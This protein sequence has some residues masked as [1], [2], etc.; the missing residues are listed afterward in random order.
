MDLHSYLDQLRSSHPEQVLTIDRCISS[1]QQI[2]ALV[3]QLEAQKKLPVLVFTN[4]VGPDGRRAECP[5]VMNLLASPQRCA[6]A[7]GAAFERVGIDYY[8]RARLQRRD[9]IVV[10]A[11]DAPVKQVVQTGD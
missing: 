9:P 2:T 1:N 6:E 8:R 7:M 11:S 3:K 4:V 5:L 10:E